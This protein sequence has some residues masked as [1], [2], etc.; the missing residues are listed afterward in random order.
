MKTARCC[1]CCR[2]RLGEGFGEKKSAALPYNSVFPI[3]DGAEKPALV[4][5]RRWPICSQLRVVCQSLSIGL[6]TVAPSTAKHVNAIE[7][8]GDMRN[9]VARGRLGWVAGE[10]AGG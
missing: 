7:P 4:C 9:N 10:A 1:C 3:S 8:R 6:L 2:R 5:E